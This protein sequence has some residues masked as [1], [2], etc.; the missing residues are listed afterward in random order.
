MN[1]INK[2]GTSYLRWQSV[3]HVLFWF[4][5]TA[6]NGKTVTRALQTLKFQKARVLKILKIRK[7]LQH[8]FPFHLF[9][10]LQFSW[11]NKAHTTEKWFLQKHVHMQVKIINV[12]VLDH[13]HA[14]ICVR[15]KLHDASI[16]GIQVC[17]SRTFPSQLPYQGLILMLFSSFS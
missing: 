7:Q 9:K 12:I 6:Q 3:V 8:V 13:G 14:I 1:K 16:R 5:K 2:S 17:C 15:F 10:T 4:W 11:K